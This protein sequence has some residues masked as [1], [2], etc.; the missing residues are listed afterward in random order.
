[1]GK[2]STV[3]ELASLL[4]RSKAARAP[5]TGYFSVLDELIQDLPQDKEFSKRE[6]LQRFQPGT[7]FKREDMQWPLKKTE[8]DYALQPALADKGDLDQMEVPE[9]L[10]RVRERR[11]EFNTINDMTKPNRESPYEAYSTQSRN[12]VPDSYFESLTDSPD[13]GRM[14]THF[15]TRNLSFS[16]GAVH[17]V[18]TLQNPEL[19]RLIDEIQND[20]ANLARSERGNWN[21]EDTDREPRGWRSP[22]QTSRLAELEKKVEDGKAELARS[23]DD[24]FMRNLSTH[25]RGAMFLSPSEMDEA[26]FIRSMPPDMPFKDPADYG[27]LEIKNG[28]LDAIANEQHGVGISPKSPVGQDMSGQTYQKVYPGEL[29]KIANQYGGEMTTAPLHTTAGSI[30]D[31]ADTEPRIADRDYFPTLEHVFDPDF[32][33]RGADHPLNPEVDKWRNMGEQVDELMYQFMPSAPA[34]YDALT[35]AQ[36]KFKFELQ[37]YE[38]AMQ[39]ADSMTDVELMQLDEIMQEHANRVKDAA[40]TAE[41][42]ASTSSFDVPYARITP[43]MKEKILKWGLPLFSAAGA[44]V[45]QMPQSEEDGL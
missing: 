34:D 45:S 25:S 30:I 41:R 10:R 43:E 18:G 19:M 5:R 39:H 2:L 42:N 32:Y 7:M 3:R 6:F 24:S 28:I 4:E 27:R 9:L 8:I 17:N 33:H 21:F 40:L 35:A 37:R 13:L 11:P 36:H 16:R 12:R 1:M 44:T 20:R 26:E 14:N 15:G 38:E 31:L 22:E 23:P 29:R